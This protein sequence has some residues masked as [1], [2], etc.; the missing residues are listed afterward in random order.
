MPTTAKKIDIDFTQQC[1]VLF[2]VTFLCG[3]S[4]QSFQMANLDIS[5]LE[6]WLIKKK[7]KEHGMKLFG[8]DTRRWFKMQKL[9]SVVS[10][11]MLFFGVLC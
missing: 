2:G 5:V 4:Q 3:T 9:K 11:S 10:F 1:I 6:G 7:T 8:S